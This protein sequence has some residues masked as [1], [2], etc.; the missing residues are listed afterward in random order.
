MQKGLDTVKLSKLDYDAL[1]H[2]AMAHSA[3]LQLKNLLEWNLM[4]L[5]I[6]DIEAIEENGRDERTD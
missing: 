2:Y 3:E 1:N 6:Q 4:A 5:G